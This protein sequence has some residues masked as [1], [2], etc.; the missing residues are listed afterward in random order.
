MAEGPEVVEEPTLLA[1]LTVVESVHC[2]TVD[3]SPWGIST[4]FERTLKTDEQPYVRKLTA[5]EEWTKLDTGWLTECS[6]LVLV[7][8]EG[9]FK[10][11]QPT[12]EQKIESAKKV[13]EV[14]CALPHLDTIRC[15]GAWELPPKESMRGCPTE[16]SIVFVRC[17]HGTAKFTVY[18][19]PS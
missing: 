15:I 10:G 13:I 9:L 11:R 2:Q 12:P 8:E 6:M 7:N 19:F 16:L 14:G 4:S 3:S 17:Q 5:T 1:R 18:I